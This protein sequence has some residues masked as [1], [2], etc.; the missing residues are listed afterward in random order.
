MQI[1]LLGKANV[2][3]STFFSAATETVVQTGN[4]PFTTIEPN[5]GVGSI[6]FFG[7]QSDQGSVQQW[8]SLFVVK[9]RKRNPPRTLTR[10]TPIRTTL[11]HGVNAR[12]SPIW[13]PGNG[14]NRRLSLSSTSLRDVLALQV[15][16]QTHRISAQGFLGHLLKDSGTGKGLSR[17]TTPNT[18]GRL[19]GHPHRYP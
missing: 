2:G 11:E 17:R 15:C 6:Y 7:N 9:N 3:K 12:A 8:F 19:S 4:F 10:D 16:H 18:L 5:V 14:I 13:H 1:G